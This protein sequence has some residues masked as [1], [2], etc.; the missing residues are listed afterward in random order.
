MFTK[1]LLFI[2]N[3]NS[4]VRHAR[5]VIPELIDTFTERGY[6]TTLCCTRARGD[7]TVFARDHAAEAD[8]VVVSGGDGTL[9]EVVTGLMQAGLQVPIGYLPAGSTND[10][11]SGL[12]IP[13]DLFR[14]AE[15]A[16]SGHGQT[17]DVG[18]FG[19][20]YFCYTAGF[21][22]FTGVSWGTP[23][24]VKNILGHAA[25][26]LEGIRSLGDIRPIHARVVT[27]DAE[28]EDDWLFGA[29]CNSTSLGGVLKLDP[30]T[31]DMN[32]GVFETVLIRNPRSAGELA[33]IIEALASR[34]Y[35]DPM[36][37]FIRAPRLTFH[38]DSAL[39]WTL[40]GEYASGAPEVTI[41]NLPNA[42]TVMIPEV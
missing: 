29:V 15:I 8:L 36:L 26:V 4:G 2:L 12:K 38:T 20:R 6:L 17:L 42:I 34:N 5:R 21:G 10:F 13:T 23:Q 39:S 22:A 9:N 1:R 32:D 3:P 30:D 14:A 16:V 40:D 24:N 18:R 33:R 27:P 11:A 37:A 35:E 28:A 41:E 25:Y 31:V 7:A 19:D